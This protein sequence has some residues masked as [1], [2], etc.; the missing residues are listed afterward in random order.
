MLSN[1]SKA[2]PLIIIKS[3]FS[4]NYK[5]PYLLVGVHLNFIQRN[6]SF[7]SKE[8]VRITQPSLKLLIHSIKIYF[9]NQNKKILQ[10]KIDPEQIKY[11]VFS[12]N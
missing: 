12:L 1:V 5:K 9:W 2:Q 10:L 3:V 8:G 7:L 6:H 4:D 11:R